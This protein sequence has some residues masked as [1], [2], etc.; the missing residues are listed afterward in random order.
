[1]TTKKEQVRAKSEDKFW[2]EQARKA[3]EEGFIGEDASARLI[4]ASLKAK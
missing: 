1:M 3:A 2:G 4:A